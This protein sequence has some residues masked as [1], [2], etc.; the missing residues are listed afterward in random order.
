M[1]QVSEIAPDTYRISTFIPDVNLQ[2]N[3]FLVLDDE[4]LLYHTGMRGLFPLVHEAVAGLVDPA[5]IRWIGFSHFEADE[6]G[7]LNEW[8]EVAPH[9]EAVCS[10]TGKLVSIDDFAPARPAKG[11]AGGEAFTTGRRRFRFM[12]TPHLPHGW[13]A[14]MLYEETTG[15]LFCSDLLHQNGDVEARTEGD[16]VGRFERVLRG[17]LHGPLPD[18]MPWT[19]RTQGL[20]ES[21]AALKPHTLA[22]MHGSA[23][24]GD[25]ERAILEAAAMMEAALGSGPGAPAQA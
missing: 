13:D 9:A 14:G 22:A 17:Y 3:Q 5:R 1:T 19:P 6:C 8:Y 12:Q 18:Y 20:L 2:F 15:T 11:L 24:A 23:F 21:L 4:P 25:G 16:V 7:S 10:L